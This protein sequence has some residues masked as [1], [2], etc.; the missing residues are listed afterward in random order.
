V[1]RG[2]FSPA[3]V[4]MMQTTPGLHDYQ[5][6]MDKAFDLLDDNQDGVLQLSEITDHANQLSWGRDVVRLLEEEGLVEEEGMAP[7]GSTAL[8]VGMGGTSMTWKMLDRF[9][10]VKAVKDGVCKTDGNNPPVVRRS[11]KQLND[12]ELD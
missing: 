11:N 12:P 4:A 3:P 5:Q 9:N 8:P 6:F 10:L 1:V 7:G 2:R